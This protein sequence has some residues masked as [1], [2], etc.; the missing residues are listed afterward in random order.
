MSIFGDDEPRPNAPHTLGEPL[1]GLSV[2]DLDHRIGLLREEI[3]RLE[4]DRARK[5]STRDA[6][7]MA[8]K[9]SMGGN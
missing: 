2:S 6:A 9:P 7:E 3:A 4:E 1:D 5:A 8:F